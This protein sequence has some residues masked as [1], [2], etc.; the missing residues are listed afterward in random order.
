MTDHGWIKEFPGSVTV[1]DAEGVVLAMNDRAAQSH[2]A[3]GGY[4]LVG[5]SLLACHPEAARNKLEALLDS[6]QANIYTIEKAG[7]KTLVY[8]SPWF[9]NGEY[10]GIVEMTLPV[11]WDM[12]HFV[13]D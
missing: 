7:V 5:R 11:P 1:C 10:R 9:E 8:Q 4:A 3:D 13:R 6:R 12:P 2:E